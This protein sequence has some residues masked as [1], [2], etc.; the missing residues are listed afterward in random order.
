MSATVMDKKRRVTLPESVCQAIGLKP[1]NQVEWRVEE[2][3]IRGRKLVPAKV[4]KSKPMFP[5]GSLL[6]Y[7]TPERDREQLEILSGCVQGPIEQ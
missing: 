3:E 6:K 4:M 2:G 1:N 7:L 5:R